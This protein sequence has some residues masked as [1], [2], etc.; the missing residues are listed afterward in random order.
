MPR[1][2]SSRAGAVE[3]HT[4]AASPP[5]WHPP[6]APGPDRDLRGLFG[7]IAGGYDAANHLL[8]AGLDHRWRSRAAAATG[9]RPGDTVLDVCC[10][11]GDMTLAVLKRMGGRGH[12]IGCDFSRPMLRRAR[13]KLAAA[14]LQRRAT[15]LEATAEAIPLADAAV[16]AAVCAFGLRNLADPKRGL[17]EM[18]RVVRPGGR[19]TILEF[20]RPAPPAGRPQH[21]CRARGRSPA[22][23]GS[24]RHQAPSPR[25]SPTKGRG[26]VRL[27]ALGLYFRRILPTLGRWLS[28][29]DAYEYLAASIEAFGPSQATA[30]LMRDAGLAEVRVEPLPGG[31]AAVYVG[32]V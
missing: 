4:P 5:A 22:T 2:R 14:G 28:A 23:N 18:A 19:V 24:P 15:L 3:R 7:A 31:I 16:Q 11:T 10:G 6:A 26:R 9:A 17:R 13:A 29:T 1:L 20:H 27:A 25:P 8:S 21:A 32:H 12:L 30:A